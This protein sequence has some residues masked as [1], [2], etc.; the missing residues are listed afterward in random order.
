MNDRNII[1]I[2]DENR[3]SV[4][5]QKAEVF[6][7]NAGC[8]TLDVEDRSATFLIA[9]PKDSGVTI[10]PHRFIYNN[11]SEEQMKVSFY[12]YARPAGKLSRSSHILPQSI[13]K[14]KRQ[15]EHGRVYQGKNIVILSGDVIRE[16]I[17]PKAKTTREEVEEVIQLQE[18]GGLVV[19]MTPLINIEKPVQVGFEA[20]WSEV[21]R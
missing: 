1:A 7:G 14:E 4:L 15:L 21:P 6:Y 11:F 12:F 16:R 17:L 20:V 19:Q 2:A 13:H 9:N 5:E 3:E 18:G 10:I 8:I